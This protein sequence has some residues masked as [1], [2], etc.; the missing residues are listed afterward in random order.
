MGQRYGNHPRDEALLRDL[1]EKLGI[2][3]ESSVPSTQSKFVIAQQSFNKPEPVVGLTDDTWRYCVPRP[4][5]QRCVLD[6]TWSFT[7]PG[8]H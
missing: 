1:A 2:P 3:S 7:F 6:R 4:R 5:H 8:V